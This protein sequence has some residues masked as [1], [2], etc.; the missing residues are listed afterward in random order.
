MMGWLRV[1]GERIL[2]ALL[3]LGG[4]EPARCR[5]LAETAALL[6]GAVTFLRR[7]GSQG[8]GRQARRK[9]RAATD[10]A[11][12]ALFQARRTLADA[13]AEGAA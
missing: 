8:Q 2:R 3:V 10:R 9:L 13:R 7:S 11:I 1:Y 6:E 4:R 12:L 5:E